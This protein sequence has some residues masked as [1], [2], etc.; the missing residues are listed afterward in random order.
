MAAPIFLLTDFGDR[1]AYVGV[2]KA[3]MLS[4][5]SSLVI[6]DLC[7]GVEP[8][9]VVSSAYVLLSAVE[10]LPKGSIVVA[11]VDPGV[12]TSRRIGALIFSHF[13][14][15][16]PDNGIATLV[17]EHYRCEMAIALDPGH[18]VKWPPSA[19]FHGRDLFAPAAAYLASG[20]VPFDQL[21]PR[22]DARSLVRLDLNPRIDGR[23][24]EASILH[25]D[26]F[27]NLVTNV[28]AER[29]GIIHDHQWVCRIGDEIIPLVRTFADCDVGEPLAYIGSSGFVE[30][31][32]RN[33]SAAER[34]GKVP[35]IFIEQ[36]QGL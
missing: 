11:V 22:V 8:Q 21:G 33:G 4:I 28:Q 20:I 5:D 18:F 7:H 3:V 32:V 35:T 26:R 27:G 31:A 30:I 36:L 9:N 34:Y 25:I 13:V 12:G 16:A 6:V 14:L 2:M 10:Y 19:T 24:L 17:L 23:V 15:L 29:W 1:D